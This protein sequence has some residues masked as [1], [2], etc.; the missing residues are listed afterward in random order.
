MTD[1]KA[2]SPSAYQ[3]ESWLFPNYPRAGKFAAKKEFPCDIFGG[4]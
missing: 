2:S 4:L 3:E 1:E